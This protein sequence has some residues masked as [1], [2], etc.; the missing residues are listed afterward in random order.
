MKLFVI[1][2]AKAGSR[3]AWPADDELRPVSKAGRR[4]SSALAAFLANEGITRIVSSPAARC[5][6]TVEPLAENLR[7]PVDLSDAIAEGAPLDE[8]LALVDKVADETAALC[9]HGDV[10]GNLLWHFERLGV[11]VGEVRME[12]A[13]TWVFDLEAG[14]VIDARYTPPPTV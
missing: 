6:Q 1:R 5:R 9:T 2:H 14:A 11:Q 3:D 4:Q 8:S 7:L 10:V 13:S 12:K